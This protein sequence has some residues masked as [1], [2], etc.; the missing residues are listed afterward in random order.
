[1]K[2]TMKRKRFGLVGLF[3]MYVLHAAAQEH[4]TEQ[5]EQNGT[6]TSIHSLK[7]FFEK[8]KFFAHARSF[9]MATDNKDSLADYAAWALGAG[10]GYESAKFKGFQFAVSGFFI[11]NIASS[12]LTKRDPQTNTLSRYEL[13]LF[14]IENQKNKNDLDRLEELYLM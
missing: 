2:V 4:R 11:S 8:G 1:M 5:Q 3:L 7:N 14:D 10:I 6:D 12:D 13:S 9:V